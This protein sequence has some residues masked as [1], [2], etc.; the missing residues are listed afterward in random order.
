MDLYDRKKFFGRWGSTSPRRCKD[1]YGEAYRDTVMR[2]RAYIARY[3]TPHAL[4]FFDRYTS[5]RLRC[6][7]ALLYLQQLFEC[8]SLLAYGGGREPNPLPAIYKR[9]PIVRYL[10]ANLRCETPLT[11][12]VVAVLQNVIEQ[13]EPLKLWFS[14]ENYDGDPLESLYAGRQEDIASVASAA[15]FATQLLDIIEDIR[16]EVAQCP[17]LPDEFFHVLNAMARTARDSV[18][19]R[20]YTPARYICAS[21]F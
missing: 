10:V 8:E 4:N 1:A 11:S 9:W 3:E 16:A 6:D 21:M 15:G 17:D 12:D 18:A 2:I 13:A 7:E 19:T 14:P 5:N 20:N